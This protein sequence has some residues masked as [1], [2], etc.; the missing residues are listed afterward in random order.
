MQ[1]NISVIVPAHNEE[2]NIRKC[3][4]SILVQKLISGTEINVIVIPNGCNDRTEEIVKNFVKLKK[5]IQNKHITW[6]ILTLKNGHKAKAMN[7]GRKL[8]KTDIIFYVDADCYLAKD[9]LSKICKKI[10]NN[11]DIKVFGGRAFPDFHDRRKDTMLY[12]IQMVREIKRQADPL[13][14]TIG[15]LMGFRKRFIPPFPLNTASDDTWLSLISAKKFGYNSVLIVDDAKVFFFPPKNWLD[16]IN[17]EIRFRQSTYHLI[18]LYGELLPFLREFRE[19]IYKKIDPSKA[20]VILAKVKKE[21]IPPEMITYV[22]NVIIPM[23]KECSIESNN[24]DIFDKGGFDIIHS[25][26]S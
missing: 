18:K 8:A 12:E 20:R 10:L 2:K 7:A 14:I 1:E 23:V 17:Q 22:E 9:A 19:I 26:K 21:K 25:T 4:E 6:E 16:Y 3:L 13:N 11:N 15:R 5:V 24:D